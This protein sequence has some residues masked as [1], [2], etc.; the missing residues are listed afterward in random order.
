MLVDWLVDRKWIQPDFREKS[1]TIRKQINLAIQDMPD[2]P[3][4]NTL[5]AVRA[6]TVRLID[7]V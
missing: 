5:L 3:E 4:I 7:A 1:D 2:V 6:R